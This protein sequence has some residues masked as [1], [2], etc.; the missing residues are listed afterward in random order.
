MSDSGSRTDSWD[1]SKGNGKT[2]GALMKEISED[3]S[4][5]VRKEIELAKEELGRSAT[6]K[7]K[8]AVI[9]A[10]VGVMG[11]FVLLFLLVTLRDVIDVWLPLWASDLI[12]LGLLILAAVIASL[13]ANK[14][15]KTP[16]STELTK[17]SIKEDVELAKSITKR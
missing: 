14:K 1:P 8:G 12:V 2:A 6:E 3:V 4:T 9:F 16:I 5:L 11:V 10:V 13:V 7:L 15:M 17:K